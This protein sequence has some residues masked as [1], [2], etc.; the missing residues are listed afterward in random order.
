MSLAGYKNYFNFVTNNR[1]RAL[2]FKL[3][4]SS[5]PTTFGGLYDLKPSTT[6][7]N[8]LK[9]MKKFRFQSQLH[10]RIYR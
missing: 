8:S 7:T 5:N 3:G 6:T 2:D 1:D 10:Q 9:A 4:L